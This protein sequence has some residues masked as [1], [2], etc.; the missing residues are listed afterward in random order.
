[1]PLFKPR[2]HSF[3]FVLRWRT[4]GWTDRRTDM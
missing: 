4:D 1:M 3:S 2:I